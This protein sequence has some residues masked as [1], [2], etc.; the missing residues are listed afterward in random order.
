MRWI[1]RFS[2]AAPA[3]SRQRHAL[4]SSTT[5]RE[6]RLV[7]RPLSLLHVSGLFGWAVLSRPTGRRH[8]AIVRAGA[9]RRKVA[10]V[11][12]REQLSFSINSFTQGTPHS[13]VPIFLSI[14][15][16]KGSVGCPFV[17]YDVRHPAERR[18]ALRLASRVS[19]R[20]TS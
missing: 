6:Y 19:A 11:V 1:K 9:R 5:S 7:S 13:G 2:T 18:A 20:G 10:T 17:S 16:K 3:S 4:N 15:N 8:C 14:Q 12:Q